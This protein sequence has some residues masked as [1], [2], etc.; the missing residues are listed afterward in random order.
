MTD[1][2]SSSVTPVE[3]LGPVDPPGSAPRRWAESTVQ[4]QQ[5]MIFNGPVTIVHHLAVTQPASL[6]PVEPE[7]PS[8][9]PVAPRFPDPI[10]LPPGVPFPVRRRTRA[11]WSDISAVV[12]LVL[13]SGLLLTVWVFGD[14]LATLLLVLAVAGGIVAA[15]VA[16]LGALS[17][18][19]SKGCPGLHCFGCKG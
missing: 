3:Y 2:P 6:V 9:V 15:L 17:W 11:D 4:V 16:L 5:P 14:R 19:G 10:P 13:G 12:P 1:Q 7:P 18:L 8:P